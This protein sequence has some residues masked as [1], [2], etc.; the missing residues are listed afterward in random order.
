M[1]LFLRKTRCN[2]LAEGVY[3]PETGS[4]LVKQGAQV[5]SDIK[6]YKSK[7]ASTVADARKDVVKN[8]ILIKD[9]IFQSLSGA[10]VLLQEEVQW[11]HIK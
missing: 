4:V 8:N 3:N 10:D 11:C 6:E 7:A 2:V 5:S 9:L 1:K